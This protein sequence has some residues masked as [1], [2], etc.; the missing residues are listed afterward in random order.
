MKSQVMIVVGIFA[1]GVLACVWDY[2]RNTNAIQE[3]EH[4]GFQNVE[5]SVG[6]MPYFDCPRAAFEF[7]WVGTK[8]G[9]TQSGEIC[10]RWFGNCWTVE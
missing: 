1:L 8:E 9:K 7:N 5:V 3:L 10:C 4:R 6:W 2:S